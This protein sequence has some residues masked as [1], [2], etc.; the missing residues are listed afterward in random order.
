MQDLNLRPPVCREG[1]QPRRN[2][3]EPRANTD[4]IPVRSVSQAFAKRCSSSQFF[5]VL[6]LSSG[7]QNGRLPLWVFAD[8]LIDPADALADRTLS[9]NELIPAYW[10]H[11]EGYFV[12]DGRSTSEQDII[13]RHA[14]RFVRRTYGTTMEGSSV[15]TMV[16]VVPATVGRPIEVVEPLTVVVM[17]TTALTALINRR[18]GSRCRATRVRVLVGGCWHRCLTIGFEWFD[19]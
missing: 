2:H 13:R 16:G 19:R 5:A 4:F 6:Q 14:R 8:Y 10:R 7:A 11:V 18:L 3:P 17:V 1:Q 15:G 9:V 12:K